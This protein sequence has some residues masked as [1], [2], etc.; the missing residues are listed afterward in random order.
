MLEF[1]FHYTTYCKG[2]AYKAH[3]GLDLNLTTKYHAS[4]LTLELWYRSELPLIENDVSKE[5]FLIMK[6]VFGMF[7]ARKRLLHSPHYKSDLP[8]TIFV[9]GFRSNSESGAPRNVASALVARRDRNVLVLDSSKLLS[10]AY[11]RSTHSSYFIGDELG[12]LLSSFY[13]GDILY[14]SLMFNWDNLNEVEF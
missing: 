9:H 5:R 1:F 10:V 8:M 3:L 14:A 2:T 13:R 12:K 7:G 6:E 4:M 11:I